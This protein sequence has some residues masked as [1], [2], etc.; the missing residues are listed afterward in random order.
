[1]DYHDGLYCGLIEILV[2]NSKA[3]LIAY[4]CISL[5]DRGGLQLAGH[6]FAY[7]KHGGFRPSYLFWLSSYD[8]L[9]SQ[10]KGRKAVRADF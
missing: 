1:M 5:F 8:F 9:Y 3:G 10:R 4:Q 2:L 6:L 7:E